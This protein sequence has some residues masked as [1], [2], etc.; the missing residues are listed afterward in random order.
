[1]DKANQEYWV[2]QDQRKVRMANALKREVRGTISD[3]KTAVK[4][5]I[6]KAAMAVGSKMG[7]R[8]Y[9]MK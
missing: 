8:T 6:H 2:R 7:S 1:M 5:K 9:K 3:F 4:S